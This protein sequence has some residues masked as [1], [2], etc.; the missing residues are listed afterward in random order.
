LSVIV[1]QKKREGRNF[2]GG[3]DTGLRREEV[4]ERKRG[5]EEESD[6]METL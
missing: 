3:E 5:R 2:E 1:R 6:D 4:E